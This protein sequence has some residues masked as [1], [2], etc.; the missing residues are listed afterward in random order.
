[1]AAV[2]SIRLN[3]G[4]REIVN[5]ILEAH[6]E[7]DGNTSRAISLALHEWSKAHPS[8]TFMY[9]VIVQDLDHPQKPDIIRILP[10][11]GRTNQSNDPRIV[12]WLGTINN[13]SK[14]ALGKLTPAETRKLLREYEIQIPDS[15]PVRFCD[16]AA[17]GSAE[18]EYFNNQFS[19]PY[20]GPWMGIPPDEERWAVSP[21]TVKRA[22]VVFSNGYLTITF[23]DGEQWF[24]YEASPDLNTRG[25]EEISEELVGKRFDQQQFSRF[26]G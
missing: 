25:A 22:Q 2:T 20:Q 21:A 18:A 23:T 3:D 15:V 6:P 11:P 12:G 24:I 5:A 4:E 9:P 7:L 14:T 10:E 16:Y 1:M 13:V 19:Y 26:G 8:E 17:G